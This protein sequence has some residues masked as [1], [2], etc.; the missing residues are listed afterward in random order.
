MIFFPLAVDGLV[1]LLG[2]VEAVHHR[3][4]VREQLA[5]GGVERRAHVGP[6]RLHPLPLL[7]R[8]LPQALLGRRLV[9]AV[10]HGQHLGPLGCATS[11]NVGRFKG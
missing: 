11:D 9:A 5:A 7:L 4:G 10:G 8:Q 6:V 2:D 3:L 1:E